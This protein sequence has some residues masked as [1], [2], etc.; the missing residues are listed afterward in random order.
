MSKLKQKNLYKFL[1]LIIFN[2]WLTGY[3]I[4]NKKKKKTE[5]YKTFR[6]VTDRP[7][8]AVFFVHCQ[9]YLAE[10]LKWG[11]EIQLMCLPSK[12]NLPESGVKERV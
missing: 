11:L 2:S 4:P 5:K 1:T 10:K 8:M 6:Q 7:H 12:S 9:M 3:S